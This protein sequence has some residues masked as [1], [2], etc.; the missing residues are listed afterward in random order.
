MTALRMIEMCI[1]D[2]YMPLGFAGTFIA[3]LA[4]AMIYATA[5]RGKSGALEGLRFGVPILS[6]IHI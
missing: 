1:R 5:Y 6:L 4:L 3:G 2:R